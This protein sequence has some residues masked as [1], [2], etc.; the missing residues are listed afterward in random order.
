MS[1]ILARFYRSYSLQVLQIFIRWVRQRVA[2]ESEIDIVSVCPLL[3]SLEPFISCEESQ[4]LLRSA[5][6]KE[7]TGL[8]SN[9]KDIL[10]ELFRT[11]STCATREHAIAG[12]NVSFPSQEVQILI[13]NSLL[14]FFFQNF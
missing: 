9:H 12:G 11:L 5:T 3:E 10:L 13:F 14:V 2:E 8:M 7:F 1:K 4:L 6:T